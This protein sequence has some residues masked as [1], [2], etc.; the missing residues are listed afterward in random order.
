[1]TGP[2]SATGSVF[3]IA[4][5]ETRDERQRRSAVGSGEPALE[6]AGSNAGLSCLTWLGS[7]AELGNHRALRTD[8][9]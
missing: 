7:A 5:E 1:M 6:W 4:G 8:H 2:G 3:E 9:C